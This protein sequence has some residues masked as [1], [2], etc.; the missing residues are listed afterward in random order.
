MIL[1]GLGLGLLKADELKRREEA[2]ADLKTLIQVFRTQVSFSARPLAEIIRGDRD[3][4]FC[5]LAARDPSLL[6]D[7]GAAL[8]R[9]GKQLL[10]DR[11]DLELCRGLA[12]GLGRSGAQGQLE[13]LDL[14][15]SLLEKRLLRAADS[16]EKGSR[17]YVCL[18][19]FGGI[20]LC[21][22]LL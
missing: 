13:H 15:A 7:P 3:S 17:L 21:L 12:R 6:E 20:V 1:C 9:A 14:Y 10:K 18:G 4:R 16:R 8:E 2:L 5:V 11:G 19:L 22:I